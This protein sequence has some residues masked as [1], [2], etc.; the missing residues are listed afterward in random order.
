MP[1]PTPAKTGEATAPVVA[2]ATEQPQAATD[3]WSGFWEGAGATVVPALVWAAF[4]IWVLVKFL[5]Q[6][7]DLLPRLKSFKGLGVEL[8]LA[9]ADLT[10]A[11]QQRGVPLEPGGTGALTRRL[12]RTSDILV[13]MRILWVDDQPGNNV[14]EQVLLRRF[15]VKIAAATTTND[16]LK[17]MAQ[18]SYDAV[19]T[20]M[21][22][23]EGNTA[24]LDLLKKARE[25]EI[26][27]PFLI[28]TGTDQSDK[29][30]PAGLFGITN[31]PDELMNLILDIRERDRFAA[32]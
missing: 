9:I 8:E 19:I 4:G 15:G 24:G 3:V 12:D 31:R 20:D 1:T 21:S 5:P 13:G 26:G 11:S 17:L 28:Y 22:R 23:P 6:L 27:T 30:R 25:A 10:Q 16:A 7:L 2:T 29:D 32:T 14:A 18:A